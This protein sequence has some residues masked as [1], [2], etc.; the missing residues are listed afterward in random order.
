MYA[1][2]PHYEKNGKEYNEI[3]KRLKICRRAQGNEIDK[4]KGLIVKDFP[5]S[6]TNWGKVIE[7]MTD[8]QKQTIDFNNSILVE[9]RPYFMRYLYSNYN[10]KYMKHNYNYDIYA[11]SHF[12]K[13]RID[14][15]SSNNS[16]LSA[17]ELKFKEFYYKFSPLVDSDC[18]M[19]NVCHYMEQN[20][21]EIKE[22][23][24]RAIS[25]ENILLLKDNDI[26]IDKIKLKRLYDLFKKYKSEKRNF[27]NIMDGDIE[28]FKTIEQ[29][30]KFIKTEAFNI[31][32]D[33]QE[34]ANLAISICYE[35]HPNDN[36]TFAWGVFGEEIINNVYKN[37]QTIVKIP[38]VD[39]F[40]NIEWLGNKYSSKEIN[41]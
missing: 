2:L 24:R 6:W 18:L 27:A 16:A 10:K 34:L 12:G 8:E 41:I 3:I 36:K 17:D 21:K 26:E 20:I 4:A 37:R 5:K 14:I 15:L 11:I 39:D 40:G 9:K 7:G 13:N 35:I 28:R 33:G 32:S 19:N 23:G 1:M 22:N 29:Y 31:S 30:N 25:D 38:F